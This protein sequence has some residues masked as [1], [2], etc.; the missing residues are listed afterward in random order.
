MFMAYMVYKSC[1]KVSGGL[2]PGYSS[3]MMFNII[4]DFFIGLVPFL[5][6]LG[7]A[8][9][10]A[11]TRN[12]ALLY[13]MLEK[14]ARRERAR[15]GGR[16]HPGRNAHDSGRSNGAEADNYMGYDSTGRNEMMTPPPSYDRAMGREETSARNASPGSRTRTGGGGGRPGGGWFGGSW[17]KNTEPDLERG[18]EL[19]PV[20]P[21]RPE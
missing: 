18:E 19:P 9:F 3:R 20:L 6:D 15:S 17:R 2:D 5:G 14:R 12:A 13:E 21:P 16:T 1:C 7:D 4:F 10:K 8:L 11:N